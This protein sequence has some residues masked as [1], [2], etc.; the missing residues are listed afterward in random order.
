[1]IFSMRPL[2]DLTENSEEREMSRKTT[3]F[4]YKLPSSVVNVV[5][6]IIIDYNRREGA[7]KHSAISGAVLER[8]IE[9][10]SAI[11][12]GLSEIETGIRTYM[13]EDIIK[14]VGYERSLVQSLL[15]KNAYYRRRR[16]LIYDI[17]V[18]LSLLNKS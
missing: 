3:Y 10:N 15:S 6:C 16:K 17:A 18:E 13:L 1:M 11:D 14:G 4:Q 8:Y 9:L 5:K 12:K 2:K 7:I